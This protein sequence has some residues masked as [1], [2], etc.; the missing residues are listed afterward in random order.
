[1]KITNKNA[2][3]LKFSQSGQLKARNNARGLG[4]KTIYVIVAS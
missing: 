4:S 1:M 2:T 3:I